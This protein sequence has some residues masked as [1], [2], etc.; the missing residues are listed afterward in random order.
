MSNTGRQHADAA[1]W[2]FRER[3]HRRILAIGAL[4]PFAEL[5][6]NGRDLGPRARERR[7]R[8]EPRQQAH[9]A[10]AAELEAI[11]AGHDRRL[12]PHGYPE[13]EA[14]SRLAALEPWW[15]NPDDRHRLAVDRNPPPQ[16]GVGRGKPRHPVVI[17]EDH[18][19]LGAAIVIRGLQ[20]PAAE[21][22]NAEHV[23][24]VAGHELAPR[25]FRFA[26]DHDADGQI[27]AAGNAVKC[28]RLVTDISVV[29]KREARQRRAAKHQRR[30]D[31]PF[32]PRGSRQRVQQD[33]VDP[34]ED[35]GVGTD[36]DRQ[37]QHRNRRERRLLPQHPNGE[38]D[39][40]NE[41]DHQRIS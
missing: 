29:G 25:P 40:L 19:R 3:K 37:H 11:A 41:R 28:P 35:G 13:I 17:A 4:I 9:P 38:P 8:R 12:Q 32:G 2:R 30:L 5:L 27:A 1:A 14:Q 36:P 18:H 33:R 34:A 21:G 7:A 23:E 16:H 22:A 31:Q 26:I 39:I 6:D 20:H 10:A 24:E 15:R